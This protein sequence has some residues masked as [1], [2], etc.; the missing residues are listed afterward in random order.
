MVN[1]HRQAITLRRRHTSLRTGSLEYLS[2][3]YG[4]LSFG[5][6]NDTEHIA[7]VINNNETQQK[8][9]LP[10]WKMGV[11]SG[12]MRGLLATYGGESFTD[13]PR[14]LIRDGTVN[15][16]LPPFGGMVLLHEGDG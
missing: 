9:C 10:V 3:R 6:W 13:G 5:R 1:L 7:V 12:K 2:N 16:T 4:I 15:L 11:S 8:I 14:F